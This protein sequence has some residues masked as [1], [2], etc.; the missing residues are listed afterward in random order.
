M[1]LLLLVV[2]LAGLGLLLAIVPTIPW[3]A[4][5]SPMIP[6]AI[7]FLAASHNQQSPSTGDGQ[8]NLVLAIGAV[9]LGIE[10]AA[11]G[12]GWIIRARQQR[13]DG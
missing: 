7:L 10:L 8:P 6:T 1:G 13:S 12:L 11:A 9:A 3:W 2:V 5:L 4:A